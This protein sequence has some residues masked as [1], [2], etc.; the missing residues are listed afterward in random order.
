MA[1]FTYYRMGV[2]RQKDVLFS[3]IIRISREIGTAEEWIK[4]MEAAKDCWHLCQSI[5]MMGDAMPKSMF[6]GGVNLLLV[7]CGL[8]SKGIHGEDEEW[9]EKA[10]DIRLVLISLSTKLDSFVKEK[11]A[12]KRLRSQ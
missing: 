11:E 5:K 7:L 6:V 4:P 10:R 8:L 2:E 1:A 3:E 9:L 12:V